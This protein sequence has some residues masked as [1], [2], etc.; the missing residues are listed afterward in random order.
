MSIDWNPPA[1]LPDLRRVGTI[2][3][4]SEERDTGLVDGVG[5]GWPWRGGFVSGLSVA[6]RVDGE[7]HAHYFPLR[8]PDTENVDRAALIRWLEDL[9]AS[10]VRIITQNGLFDYGWL[11]ADLGVHMPPAERL[12]EIGALATIVD[13]KGAQ[14]SG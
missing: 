4:D 11:C 12:E 13:E 14:R 10:D 3:L 9:F 5:S 1:E 7:V 8:H 2:A 6:Y